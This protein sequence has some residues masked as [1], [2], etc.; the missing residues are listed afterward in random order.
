MNAAGVRMVTRSR[1]QG[2]RAR[3]R[4]GGEEAAPLQRGEASGELARGGFPQAPRNSRGSP[5]REI[6]W[7]RSV[8]GGTDGGNKQVT[9][10]DR[11]PVALFA[12]GRK[13][14]SRVKCQQKSQRVNVAYEAS[15]GEKGEDTEPLKAPGWEPQD[16]QQQLVNIRTMRSGKDAPVDQ[17]GVEHCY[18]PSAPPKVRRYQVLLSLMLSSQTKDQV[19]AG[20]MQR[21]RAW[22]LTVD[23]ILQTDD[24]T[25]GTLIYPVGFWRRWT[26]T[27]T[28]SPTDSGGPR[29]QPSPQR[30]PAP[31]WRSGCPGSCGARS[32]DCWWASDS[33]PVC[34]S[35]HAARP[36]SIGPCVQLHRGSEGRGA[37][38]RAPLWP[39]S[40][41]CLCW[42][43]ATCL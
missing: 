35:A 4:R 41:M 32:T 10:P 40:A 2:S 42:G 25:L 8:A 26:H 22:G 24:S 7:G 12:E 15:D 20:A 9:M 17:L 21:L 27:C 23:S 14:H 33:R 5:D 43:A 3:P 1:S 34:L 39:L 31:P 16:W 11:D 28:G 37:S 13:S 6:H 18:D 29:R 30:R 19:T 36:A 38:A